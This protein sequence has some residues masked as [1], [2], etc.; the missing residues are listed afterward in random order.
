M[1]ILYLL[2]L[3]A[4][5]LASCNRSTS[6]VVN[7]TE[8]KIFSITKVDLSGPYERKIDSTVVFF[9]IATFKPDSICYYSW[10]RNSV[11]KKGLN[12]D[13]KNLNA[14]IRSADTD[15]IFKDYN[16]VFYFINDNCSLQDYKRLESIS[17][18]VIIEKGQFFTTIQLIFNDVSHN[19]LLNHSTSSDISIAP[20]YLDKAIYTTKDKVIKS[21]KYFF[22]DDTIEE[23]II[24]T[25]TGEDIEIN[26]I[27]KFCEEVIDNKIYKVHIRP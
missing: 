3:N 14:Y 5:I 7:P 24:E 4:M 11:W 25:K 12:L 18:S 17:D 10:M 26:S 22:S 8:G 15:D 19:V 21:I 1:K 16:G 6:K 13:P 20:I 9:N 2:V 23:K 27:V